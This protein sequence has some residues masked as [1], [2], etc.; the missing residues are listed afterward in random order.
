MI[1]LFSIGYWNAEMFDN[2][3]KPGVLYVSKN[4][5]GNGQSFSRHSNSSYVIV[6]G[7]GAY[8]EGS[9]CPTS[10]TS[11]V[12]IGGYA[13]EW[14]YEMVLNDGTKCSGSQSSGSGY[15]ERTATC[16]DTFY[17]NR[18]YSFKLTITDQFNGPDDKL[19]VKAGGS[20]LSTSNSVD[21]QYNDCRPGYFGSTC[22]GPVTSSMCTVDLGISSDGKCKD[23]KY[24]TS[25]QDYCRKVG[26]TVLS[27]QK[28]LFRYKFVFDSWYLAAEE[29]YPVSFS[30]DDQYYSQFQFYGYILIPTLDTIKI[31]LT[32]NTPA[33]LKVGSRQTSSLITFA[34]MYSCLSDRL[35]EYKIEDY[36]G[37]VEPVE[38]LIDIYGGC[39]LN[40]VDAVLRWD[41]GKG[42]EDIPQ[43]F[44]YHT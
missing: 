4:T 37:S 13:N 6:E 20:Y 36:R 44:F 24:A 41:L 11:S 7:D 8:M 43:R 21:C 40:H 3:C 35:Y 39:P 31:K 5:T 29:K 34:E 38:I 12:T 22:E 1:F 26:N 30:T 42:Y 2:N 15:H 10:D 19:W 16:S 33:F 18:C 17:S 9:F 28:L 27:N 23:C 32:S 14:K 25:I